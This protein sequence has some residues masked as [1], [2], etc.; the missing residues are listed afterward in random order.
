[1]YQYWVFL[2]SSYGRWKTQMSVVLRL[3]MTAFFCSQMLS[4]C[5]TAVP[6]TIW[7]LMLVKRN[8]LQR[9]TIMRNFGILCTDRPLFSSRIETIFPSTYW[10]FIFSRIRGILVFSLFSLFKQIINRFMGF[11]MLSE[12]A[13]MNFWMPELIFMKSV[14]YIMAPDPIWMVYF[15]NS[16]HQTVHHSY[17]CYTRARKDLFL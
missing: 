7:S 8:L 3:S 1:M 14:M 16:S 17:R 9:N 15:T 5:I 2:C 4:P 11:S 10:V 13:P 6:L 12:S